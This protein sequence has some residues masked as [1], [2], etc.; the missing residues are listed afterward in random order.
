MYNIAEFGKRIAGLRRNAGMSQEELAKCLN[1]TSQAVSKWEN[2]LSYPDVTTIPKVAEALHTTIE[3]LYGKS[4]EQEAVS[5]AE[6]DAPKFPPVIAGGLSL[7]HKLYNTGCY[8]NKEVLSADNDSVLFKDGSKANLR[9]RLIIN[10]GRGEIRFH[11]SEWPAP[12]AAD[13]QTV[14]KQETF[15]AVKSIQLNV[16]FWSYEIRRSPD[17]QTRVDIRGLSELVRHLAISCE[18]ELLKI[19]SSPIYDDRIRAGTGDNKITIHFGADKGKSLAAAVSGC[20]KGMIRV[21]FCTGNIRISG[22]GN[23][24]LADMDELVCAISGSGDIRGGSVGNLDL[25]I[26]GSGDMQFERVGGVMRAKISGSGDMKIHGGS[27]DL[28]SMQISGSGE[29]DARKVTVREAEITIS[30]A[31]D[32]TIGRVLEQS[33]EK[34]GKNSRINILQRGAE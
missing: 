4:V 26:S 24:I 2:G 8:T 9:T 12:C 11:E 17:E 34:C 16:S 21:P 20:G 5:G 15:R 10:R 14:E 6:G 30:G 27:L 32:V 28:L 31:G 29:L 23:T 13:W 7:V 22:S 33:T 1:V 25:K 18:D 19:Q 3:R